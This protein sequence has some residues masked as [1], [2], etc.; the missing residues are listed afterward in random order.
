LLWDQLEVIIDQL[1]GDTQGVM[2][3]ALLQEAVL[4]LAKL[5]L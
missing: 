3:V 5:P 1:D 2:L 4:H